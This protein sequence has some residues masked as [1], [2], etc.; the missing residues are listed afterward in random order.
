MKPDLVAVAPNSCALRSTRSERSHV[1]PRRATGYSR[2][3]TSTLWLKTSGASAMTRAS[4][5]SSPRKSGVRTST[6]QVGAWRRIW[7]MVAA[8]TPA[9]RSGRSSRSTLVTTAWRRPMRATDLATRAGSSGS[10][11]VGLPVLTL[12]KPQRRVHVSPRIMK[13]AVPRSQQSPMFGQAASWQTVCRSS[14]AMSLRS[15]R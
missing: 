14:S 13:V 1:E 6:L 9:P 10:C 7:R 2:G 12:Q 15:A 3:A 8:Q 11:H 5:I 4:G